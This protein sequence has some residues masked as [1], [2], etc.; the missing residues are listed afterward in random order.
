MSLLVSILSLSLSLSPPNDGSH[1]VAEGSVGT[2]F[3]V[4]D[5]AIS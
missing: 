2:G 4:I 3:S 1:M 5:F